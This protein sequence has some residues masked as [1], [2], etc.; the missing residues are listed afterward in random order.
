MNTLLVPA[1]VAL[2]VVA[3]A[4]GPTSAAVAPPTVVAQ[5]GGL[6][7]TT[8]ELRDAVLEARRTGQPAALAETMSPQGLERIALRVLE[9]KAVAQA[10]RD[11]GLDKAPDVARAIATATDTLLAQALVDHEVRA[12]GSSDAELRRYYDTHALAFRSEARRK[13]HHIVVKTRAEAE[14]ALAEVKAGKPFAEVAAARNLDASKARS[15]DLGWVQPG[16]MVKPFDEALFALEK[17]GQMSGII[18]TSFGFHVIRLDEADL[19]RLLPFESVKSQVRQV[20]RDE[21]VARL[22][23]ELSAKYVPLVNKDALAKFQR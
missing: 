17:P 15:G 22:K 4:Q 13:A 9:R 5:A 23:R 3:S 18:E 8:D 10:A 11:A 14:A 12:I 2:S 19:G 21:A 20:A 16:V 6:A 1:I 7:V